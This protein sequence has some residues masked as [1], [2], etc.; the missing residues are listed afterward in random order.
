[1]IAH[2]LVCV[3]ESFERSCECRHEKCYGENNEW[4]DRFRRVEVFARYL[5]SEEEYNKCED[6]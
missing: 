3:E 6:C 2:M 4:N 5:G 1:M